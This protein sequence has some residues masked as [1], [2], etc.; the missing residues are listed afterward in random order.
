[1]TVSI[2]ITCLTVV[3]VPT[4][5]CHVLILKDDFH[6]EVVFIATI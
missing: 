3:V 2:M 4:L 5:S 6:L 1:M